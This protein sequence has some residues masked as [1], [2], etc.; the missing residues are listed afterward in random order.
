MGL[1]TC[2]RRLLPPLQ[3]LFRCPIQTVTSTPGPGYSTKTLVLATPAYTKKSK[4]ALSNG[5][6][7]GVALGVISSRIMG[8][9]AATSASRDVFIE[10]GAVVRA[11]DLGESN[12]GSPGNSKG[13]NHVGPGGTVSPQQP[14]T[15]SDGDQF[16]LNV[17]HTFRKKIIKKNEKLYDPQTGKLLGEI[18]FETADA[19]CEVGIS[20]GSKKNQLF[21]LAEEAMRRGKRLDVIYGP[22]TSPGTLADFA[23]CLKA[24]FGSRVRFIPHAYP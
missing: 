16:E 10:G 9:A 3:L 5:D 19:I 2:A 7:P 15:L 17:Q 8:M 6:Q 22:N 14:A 24:K 1:W 12:M 20:L 4:I 18:D 13:Q 11:L 23:K 21:R